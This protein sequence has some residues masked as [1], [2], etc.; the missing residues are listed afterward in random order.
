MALPRKEKREKVTAQRIIL[1]DE[2]PTFPRRAHAGRVSSA[3]FPCQWKCPGGTVFAMG[4]EDSP[5]PV[6]HIPANSDIAEELRS[7]KARVDA[8][9]R[10]FALRRERQELGSTPGKQTLHGDSAEDL[11]QTAS[12]VAAPPPPPSP[13]SPVVAAPPLPAR[14]L[15][16]R[17]GAQVFNRVGIVALMIGATWFLK[18]AIDNQW[19]GPVGRVLIGL[20]AGAG[21][22]LWSDGFRW[23]GVPA[24]YYYLYAI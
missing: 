20:I 13:D 14:S 4:V 11:A 24:F 1:D 5:R 9:E 10:E 22:W 12:A 6:E 2:N 7:L 16:S 15:E 17:L 23:I 8:L 19:V 21:I 18:L 3:G